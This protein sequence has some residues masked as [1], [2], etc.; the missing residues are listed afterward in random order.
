MIQGWHRST[1]AAGSK[2]RQN[3]SNSLLLIDTQCNISLLL[4][5][6]YRHRHTPLPP[7]S[8]YICRSSWPLQKEGGGGRERTRGNKKRKRGGKGVSVYKAYPPPSP[9]LPLCTRSFYP[10]LYKYYW[11]SQWKCTEEM[12]TLIPS[13]SDAFTTNYRLDIKSNL[14]CVKDL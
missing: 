2:L 4:A 3:I 10:L 14:H 11:G 9:S 12:S 5:H 7:A 8:P 1:L 13:F 6:S